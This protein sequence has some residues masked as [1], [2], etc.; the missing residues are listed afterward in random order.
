[1]DWA[2][3][4]GKVFSMIHITTSPATNGLSFVCIYLF[5]CFVLFLLSVLA[6]RHID[7]IPTFV[8]DK[9]FQNNIE[10]HQKGRKNS[11]KQNER[12]SNER[13]SVNTYVYKVF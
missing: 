3:H 11:L 4:P 8:L 10:R 7:Q 6:V 13:G 1:M 5:A 2:E 9:Q 12:G